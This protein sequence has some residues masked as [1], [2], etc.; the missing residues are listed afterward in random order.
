MSGQSGEIALAIQVPAVEGI[1]PVGRPDNES[2]EKGK[3]R[4]VSLSHT[5]NQVEML[6]GCMLLAVI[7]RGNG[8]SR[9]TVADRAA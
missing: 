7:V 9:A 1:Q 6:A 4:P 8:V 2:K 5:R 3:T